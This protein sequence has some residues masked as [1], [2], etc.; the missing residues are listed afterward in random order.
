MMLLENVRVGT[1]CNN[2]RL[3]T[4]NHHYMMEMKNPLGY[5]SSVTTKS[6]FYH[7][8]RLSTRFRLQFHLVDPVVVGKNVGTAVSFKASSSSASSSRDAAVG[9]YV[10]A[11]A[12]S[13]SAPSSR[14]AVVGLY[15]GI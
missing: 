2:G 12:S 8:V 15:V 13:S 5:E 14:D 7:I 6:M 1:Q 11:T 3:V 4:S 9:S 10:A